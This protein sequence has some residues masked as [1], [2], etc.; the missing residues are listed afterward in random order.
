VKEEAMAVAKRAAATAAK[1]TTTAPTTK[2]PR[3]KRQPAD[4]MPKEVRAAAAAALAVFEE[5]LLEFPSIG[6]AGA[7]TR[8]LKGA[9]SGMVKSVRFDV[10]GKKHR[11]AITVAYR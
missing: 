10:D 7:G 11:A 4:P 5:K 3:E 9:R 6:F 2:K 1:G 8:E